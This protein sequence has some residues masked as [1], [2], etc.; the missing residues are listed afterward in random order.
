A[1]RLVA[2]ELEINRGNIPVGIARRV[3]EPG[4]QS[5]RGEADMELRIV[6]VRLPH[7]RRVLGAR[8]PTQIAAH[9][10]R[11]AGNLSWDAGAEY[12]AL[13]GESDYNYPEFHVG[14]ASQRLGAR[15]SYAP[16]YPDRDVPAVYFELNGNQPMG[17]RLRLLGHLGWLRR[18][19][20]GAGDD[21]GGTRVDAQVG[22]GI[23][24]E[25]FDLRIAW[26]QVNGR[27]ERARQ[28]PIEG[29]DDSG[30][31]VTLSRAW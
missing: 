1:H 5:L 26:S 23:A 2:V 22:L 24:F 30:W 14:L 4:T 8:V 10:P 3:R 12:A 20:D 7:Q 9:A 11:I 27:D 18:G 16:R 21:G 25:P 29:N 15:L 6:V 17:R 28:Y 31:I 13:V 19:E